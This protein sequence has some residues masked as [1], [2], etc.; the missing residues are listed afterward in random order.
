M[1][2]VKKEEI[3]GVK[4]DD[5]RVLCVKCMED[6]SNYK[7]KNLIMEDEIEKTDDMYFCDECEESL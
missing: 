3:R 4:L 5:G 6:P 1:G 2:I 7:Q